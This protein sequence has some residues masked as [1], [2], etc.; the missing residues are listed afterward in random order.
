[1]LSATYFIQYPGDHNL[2]LLTDKI[3]FSFTLTQNEIQKLVKSYFRK[4]VSSTRVK[5]ES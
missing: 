4:L 5:P 3:L 1:M 2:L